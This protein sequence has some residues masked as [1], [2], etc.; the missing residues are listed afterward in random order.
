MN[1]LAQLQQTS[2]KNLQEA[3][4]LDKCVVEESSI[5]N[6]YCISTFGRVHSRIG[7]RRN[8]RAEQTLRTLIEFSL[9]SKPR[10]SCCPPSLRGCTAPEHKNG[11]LEADELGWKRD[12]ISVIVWV[13]SSAVC[14]NSKTWKCLTKAPYLGA[15]HSLPMLASQCSR[16]T[17]YHSKIETTAINPMVNQMVLNKS[18]DSLFCKNVLFSYF[19]QATQ[20]HNYPS[21]TVCWSHYAN[22]GRLDWPWQNFLRWAIPDLCSAQHE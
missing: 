5:A 7:G 3:N 6:Y 8:F 21:V 16:I 2:C 1:Y 22:I 13:W 18:N 17:V 4:R 12:V 19:Y 20:L 10:S 14:T 9:I 11:G 15:R